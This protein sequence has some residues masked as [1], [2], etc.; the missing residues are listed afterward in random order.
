MHVRTRLP[1]LSDQA[2]IPQSFWLEIDRGE[3][4]LW[5]ARTE[6]EIAIP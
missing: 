2:M 5:V 6:V 3:G 1:L 4:I